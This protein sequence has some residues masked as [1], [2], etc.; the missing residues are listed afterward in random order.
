M[1]TEHQSEIIQLHPDSTFCDISI[2]K[3]DDV[4]C[5]DMMAVIPV[6]TELNKKKLCL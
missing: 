2:K 3:S 6:L 4:R 5:S 1:F